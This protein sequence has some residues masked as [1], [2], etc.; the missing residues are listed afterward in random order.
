MVPETAIDTDWLAA[1]EKHHP[2]VRTTI[3]W[4]V[5]YFIVAIGWVVLGS[6]AEAVTCDAVTLGHLRKNGSNQTPRTGHKFL[7]IPLATG[8]EPFTVDMPFTRKNRR[9]SPLI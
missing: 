2:V 1:M 8:N 3:V 7:M 6:G 4:V 5:N 9:S